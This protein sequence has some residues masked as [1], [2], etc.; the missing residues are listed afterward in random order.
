[1]PREE[2][3]AANEAERVRLHREADERLKRK[4]T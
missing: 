3:L 4:Y 1:V 2:R